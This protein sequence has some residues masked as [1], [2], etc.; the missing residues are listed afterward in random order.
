MARTPNPFE[1]GLDRN[2]ANYVPLSPLSF[3]P[4]TASVFPDHIA[5]VHGETRR[6]WAETYRRCRRLASALAGRGIGLGDTV[7]VMAANTPELM[8]AHFGVP[9]AGAVL[10]ALNMCWKAARSMLSGL[11]RCVAIWASIDSNQAIRPS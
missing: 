5:V 7:A 2:A 1:T 6:S 9:M 8:E 4:R 11:A 3:L 10:N